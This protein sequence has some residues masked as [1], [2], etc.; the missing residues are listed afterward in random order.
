MKKIQKLAVVFL[1]S[2]VM[3]SL[4]ACSTEVTFVRPKPKVVYVKPKPKPA[5][6][7]AGPSEFRVINQYD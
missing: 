2:T 5:P 1:A 3:I 4:G 7:P 6:K